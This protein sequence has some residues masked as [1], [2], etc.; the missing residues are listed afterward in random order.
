[1]SKKKLCTETTL[2]HLPTSQRLAANAASPTSISAQQL[3]LSETGLQD[4]A[5]TGA[6]LAAGLDPFLRIE[7]VT[8]V[9][10]LS[11]PTVYRL[12]AKGEF[13]RPVK[14]T[15]SA[16]GWKLSDI[17]GWMQIRAAAGTQSSEGA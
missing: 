13:P 4:N 16:R 10:G 2:T 12:I 17:V 1:M 6:L 9:I 3:A 14:L 5:L 8:A 7:T 15:A 11:V